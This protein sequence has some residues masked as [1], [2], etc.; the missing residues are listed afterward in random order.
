MIVERAPSGTRVVHLGARRSI[1][2]VEIAVGV[3]AGIAGCDRVTR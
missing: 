2:E 3:P 1:I